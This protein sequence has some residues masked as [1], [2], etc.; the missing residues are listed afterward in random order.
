MIGKI[1][2]IE[3]F[4]KVDGPGIRYVVFMQGCNL[5]CK[6]CHNPDTW[7]I[8][9]GTEIESDE[10]VAQILKAKPYMKKSGGGV[11]FSGGEPLLQADFLIEVCKKL[12]K[13]GIHIAIDTAGN[14]DTE[15]E[16]LNELFNY[17]DLFLFDIKH[18]D[19][20]EHNLLTGAKNDAI[21]KMAKY[22]SNVWKIPMWIRIVYLPGITDK[23]NALYRLRNL[24]HTLQ[25]VEKIDV[26]P[27]HDMGV[28]KWK[29]MGL[30]YPL[31][32]QAIPS[33]EECTKLEEW[34]NKIENRTD[35][36]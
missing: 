31:E 13:H 28:Y 34:L 15:N 29:N 25:S 27:Y 2:S 9:Q 36:N 10:L 23:E 20:R 8:C 16:K 6:F 12:K 22:I 26:L 3:S 14:F 21:L 35:Y 11:T 19:T 5:R 30:K 18:I 1:H 32:G 7:N 4:S 17:I 33:K 24:I